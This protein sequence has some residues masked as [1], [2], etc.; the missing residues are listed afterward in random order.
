[1]HTPL[2]VPSVEAVCTG[3]P[4]QL[5]IAQGQLLKA[6]IHQAVDGSLSKVLDLMKPWWM[7]GFL[8]TWLAKN[9]ARGTFGKTLRNDFPDFNARIEG[10]AEGASL[11]LGTAYLVNALETSLSLLASDT[12]ILP[13]PGACS[14][15]AVRGRRS[16]S[17]EPIIARNFDY[18]SFLQPFCSLRESRPRNGYRSLEF[19]M[20]PIAGAI[21]GINEKGLSIT[22]DYAYTKDGNT[23]AAPLSMLISKALA[24]CETVQQCA[25]LIISHARW[26]G[27]I[28]MLADATGDIA[29]LEVSSTRSYLRRPSPGQ[30]VLVHTN[31]FSSP[32]MQAVEVSPKAVFG[33]DAE[34]PLRGI[35]V[36]ESAECRLASLTAALASGKALCTAE[37]AAMLADHGV[38]GKASDNTVCIHSDARSTI[39]S[40]QWFPRSRR[41][42]VSYSYACQAKFQEFQL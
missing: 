3:S 33:P 26:G 24:K 7:P 22:Y 27:G 6:K 18:L 42:R 13:A 32:H 20:A 2:L 23:V 34:V 25:D 37:L 4:R 17:G 14:A 12:A 28:L 30:D 10:I 19:F 21:D 5:G 15:V 35:R 8:F 31:S 36:L 29:S 41:A 11:S 39:A 9:K 16:A 38:D 1:M 40:L